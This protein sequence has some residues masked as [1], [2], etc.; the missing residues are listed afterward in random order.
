MAST[1]SA[2]TAWIH[3]A[4]MAGLHKDELLPGC[5][6]ISTAGAIMCLV[7]TAQA[8]GHGNRPD[9]SKQRETQV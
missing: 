8:A 7:C 2:A 1:F 3:P 5:N 9:D 4:G 6:S